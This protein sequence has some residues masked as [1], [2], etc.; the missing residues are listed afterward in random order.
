MHVQIIQQQD[1]LQINLNL[2]LSQNINNISVRYVN[3]FEQGPFSSGNKKKKNNPVEIIRTNTQ[4]Y[5]VG[6][7]DQKLQLR[8]KT[9]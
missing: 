1:I 4:A 6:F 5:A 7:P 2:R 8:L 3:W 9:R